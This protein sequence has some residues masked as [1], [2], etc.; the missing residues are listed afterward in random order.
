MRDF[1]I[2]KIWFSWFYADF[3]SS[4][5]DRKLQYIPNQ[6]ILHYSCVVQ[7]KE[8]RKKVIQVNDMEVMHK[9]MKEDFFR[10]LKGTPSYESILQQLLTML[11][12]DDA[13]L[14]GK[15]CNYIL[16]IHK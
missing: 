8:N 1:K 7:E 12:T 10:D 11:D 14:H 2:R 13:D 5:L 3:N 4:C 15:V 9:L 6:I 16:E